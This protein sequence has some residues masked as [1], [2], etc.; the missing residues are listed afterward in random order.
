M[1][2]GLI[3]FAIAIITFISLIGVKR[4]WFPQKNRIQ[5]GYI[6]PHLIIEKR[7]ADGEINH[8]EFLEIKKEFD[9]MKEKNLKK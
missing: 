7:Y 6:D 1:G 8:A 9:K 2:I 3:L 5:S 4:N